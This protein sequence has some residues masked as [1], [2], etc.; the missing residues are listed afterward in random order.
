MVEKTAAA[1]MKEPTY[2]PSM[3]DGYF[4]VEIQRVLIEKF[5]V[6]VVPLRM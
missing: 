6:V 4:S 2:I 1:A 3:R 5:L